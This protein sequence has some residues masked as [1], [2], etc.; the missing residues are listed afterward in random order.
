M[1]QRYS[2]SDLNLADFSSVLGRRSRRMD[3]AFR[4]FFDD[5]SLGVEQVKPGQPAPQ[6]KRFVAKSAT[7]GVGVDTGASELVGD[8]SLAPLPDTITDADR[9]QSTAR[10]EANFAERFPKAVDHSDV[11]IL[12]EAPSV[13]AMS[14]MTRQE[15]AV[16]EP[17]RVAVVTPVRLDGEANTASRDTLLAQSRRN[18][19]QKVD[20]R[21]LLDEEAGDADD[22]SQAQIN[23]SDGAKIPSDEPNADIEPKGGVSGLKLGNEQHNTTSPISAVVRLSPLLAKVSATMARGSKA[24][25][26]KIMAVLKSGWQAVGP[27]VVE[28]RSLIAKRAIIVVRRARQL[29]V[30]SSMKNYELPENS[31]LERASDHVTIG[32]PDDRPAMSKTEFEKIKQ[33]RSLTTSSA[34]TRI[35]EHGVIGIVQKADASSIT[36][37][38]HP[39]SIVRNPVVHGGVGEQQDYKVS[40]THSKSSPS[41]VGSTALSNSKASLFVFVTRGLIFV[42]GVAIVGILGWLAYSTVTNNVP[43]PVAIVS[44][45]QDLL[46]VDSLS[47]SAPVVVPTPIP[48][49]PAPVLE[50]LPSATDELTQI[51]ILEAEELLEQLGLLEASQ[52]DGVITQ[53]TTNAVIE[54]K[55]IT[56]FDVSDGILTRS[57]FEDLR[58]WAGLLPR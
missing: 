46:P 40:I 55:Q 17:A 25:S 1:V 23:D 32:Q 9:L 45:E 15:P 14:Y 33:N 30:S 10:R 20:Q 51:E 39:G 26:Q 54:F 57:V 41:Q 52:T 27:A 37:S 5:P 2:R 48:V 3:P 19:E 21:S 4:R 50:A 28:A 8:A 34:E 29:I 43:D 35:D 31:L 47:V 53:S 11:R 16:S 18:V 42:V 13:N 24:A 49:V 7:S 58:E 12:P 38:D 44:A 22:P 56:S 36:Q 6:R